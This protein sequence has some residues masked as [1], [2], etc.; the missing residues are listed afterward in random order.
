MDEAAAHAILACARGSEA[1][2]DLQACR[3]QHMHAKQLKV[4]EGNS[5]P[6]HALLCV[7][8]GQEAVS[9]TNG[10]VWQARVSV[11][12][13]ARAHSIYCCERRAK[14]KCLA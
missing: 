14:S 2:A 11:A 4:Q 12:G 13:N 3:W 7:T 8:K 10:A 6:H 1:A 9:K 5:F